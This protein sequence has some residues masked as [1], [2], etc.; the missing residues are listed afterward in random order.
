MK[1]R[2]RRITIAAAVLGAG[3]VACLVAPGVRIVAASRAAT[4]SRR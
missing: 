4:S 2:A 1:P 3:V